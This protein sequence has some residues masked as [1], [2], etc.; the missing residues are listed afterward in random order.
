[1][2]VTLYSQPNCGPCAATKRA[3]ERYEI[4]FTVRDVREDEEALRRVAELGYSRTPVV[5]TEDGEHWFG[6]N[7]ERLKSLAQA[8]A[9]SVA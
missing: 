2:S 6:V 5:E 1:V 9:I 7:I 3:L 4:P 8:A